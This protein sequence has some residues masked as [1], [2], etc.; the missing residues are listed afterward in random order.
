MLAGAILN[1]KFLEIVP[2]FVCLLSW[3]SL[4]MCATNIYENSNGFSL[5]V[6]LFW[7]IF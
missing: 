2:T 1:F 5:V 4:G 7:E 3:F 6:Y